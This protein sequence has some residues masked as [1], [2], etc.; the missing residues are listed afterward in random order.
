MLAS[1]FPGIRLVH[2]QH[3]D[4]DWPTFC[5]QYL[6]RHEVRPHKDGRLFSFAVYHDNPERADANVRAITGIV[7]DFDNS[8]GRGN[9]ARCSDIPSRPE[10]HFENLADLSFAWYSTHSNTSAWPK[11]RLVIPLDRE[12]APSEWPAVWDG[13]HAL[14]ARDANIDP[15]CA[16][17]SRAYYTPSCEPSHKDETFAG[18]QPGRACTVDELLALTHLSPQAGN[19]HVLPNTERQRH[20]GRNDYLKAVASAMLGRGEP[21]ESVVLELLREDAKH[22]PPLFTD[23]TEGYRGTAEAGALIFVARVAYSHNIRATRNEQPVDAI[24]LRGQDNL[25]PPA[26]VASGEPLL[27]MARD[28]VKNLKPVRWAVRGYLEQQTLA[29][30]FGEPGAGKSFVAL[31][32]ACTIASGRNWHGRAARQTPVVYVCGEGYAGLRRRM[33]GW[34]LWHDCSLDR[35]PLAVTRRAVPLCDLKAVAQL[36]DE[37]DR[38]V[39]QLGDVPGQFIVDT[40]ARNFGGLDENSTKDMMLFVDHIAGY[41]MD[42]YKAGTLLVHHSGHLDKG[43][44]RGSSALKGA[45]DAEYVLAKDPAGV[46]LEALKMKD[47][48]LPA[49]VSFEMRRIELPV[50]D[51]DGKPE[52]TVVPVVSLFERSASTSMARAGRNLGPAQRSMLDLLRTLYAQAKRNLEEGSYD[53]E[54]AR[55]TVDDWR[56]SCLEKGLFRTRQQFHTAKNALVDRGEINI[57]NGIVTVEKMAD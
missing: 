52:T 20:N 40:V 23:R 3:V 32:L 56:K 37:I 12:V 2:G 7:V 22:N 55:V 51:E 21:I 38:A 27:V 24:T 57:E 53:P 48:E 5:E 19:V 35:V 15:T 25:P 9:D 18:F 16:E 54:R 50:M 30:L 13:A 43:R 17:L 46:V 42:T 28:L 36:K 33:V 39:E 4:L 6:S 29:V 11:W 14:L 41:L 1:L 34:S 45:V 8:V 31:D 44:A 47:A 26:A 10:D 49:P